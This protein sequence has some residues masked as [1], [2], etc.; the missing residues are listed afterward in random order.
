M[1]SAAIC[2][3]RVKTWILSSWVEIDNLNHYQGYFR[4][5]FNSCTFVWLNIVKSGSWIQVTSGHLNK[6][7][8]EPWLWFVEFGS[9]KVLQGIYVYIT[10]VFAY[11]N[12]LLLYKHL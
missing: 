5:N 2:F 1:P 11:E 6:V 8:L 4:T 3:S 10:T 9:R 12:I 7:V